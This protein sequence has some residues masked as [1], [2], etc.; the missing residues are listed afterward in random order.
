MV[1]PAG[2]SF[3]T[4]DRDHDR[5]QGGRDTPGRSSRLENLRRELTTATTF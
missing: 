5:A 1:P 4:I 2:Q 3:A